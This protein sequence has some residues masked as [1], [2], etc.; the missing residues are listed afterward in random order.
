MLLFREKPTAKWAGLFV[1]VN[2]DGKMLTLDSGDRTR[3]AS[4]GKV[5]G[6]SKHEPESAEDH[7]VN[8]AGDQHIV[9]TPA[10]DLTSALDAIFDL[11]N[12]SFN[13]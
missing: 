6:Y 10:E 2:A 7:P 12:D 8:V 9:P 4:V 1:V 3:T 11:S 13:D 5:D